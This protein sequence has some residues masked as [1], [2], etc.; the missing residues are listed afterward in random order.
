MIMTENDILH[1]VMN[2]FTQNIHLFMFIISTLAKSTMPPMPPK[3][4]M[5]PCKKNEQLIQDH[6]SETPDMLLA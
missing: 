1:I 4:T 5:Y 2:V 6:L 3:G